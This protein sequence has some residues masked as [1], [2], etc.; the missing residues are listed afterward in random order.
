MI[1]KWSIVNDQSN[2]NYDV[3]NEITFNIEVLKSN[4]CYDNHVYILVRGDIIVTPA[5]VTQVWFENCVPFM[6]CITKIDGKAIDDAEDLD[7]VMPMYSLIEYSPNYSETTRSLWFYLKDETTD[8]N[9]DIPNNNN[10]KSFKY[11]AKLL[12]Y[13]V[14]QIAPN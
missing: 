9:V 7:L 8:F 4:L 11:K 10:F 12:R 1:R 13:T 5:P 6:K 3:G 2:A 14:V